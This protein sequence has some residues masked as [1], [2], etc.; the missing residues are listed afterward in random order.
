MG[1]FVA[2]SGSASVTLGSGV[3]DAVRR[4]LG[5]V[6]PTTTKVLEQTTDLIYARAEDGWPVK[7]GRSKAGLDHYTA[8]TSSTPG[9]FVVESRFVD[10]VPYVVFIKAKKLGGANPWQRLIASPL[11]DKVPVLADTLA[12]EVAASWEKK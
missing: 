3:E 5:A 11:K 7:T 12:K 1:R 8:V 10:A 2:R 9:R 4:L 6:A